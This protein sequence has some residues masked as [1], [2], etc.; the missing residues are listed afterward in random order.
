MSGVKACFRIRMQDG[1]WRYPPFQDRGEF[2][3]LLPR[4][5]AAA[6]EDVTP[7]SIDAM[8]EG[9]QPIEIAGDSMVLV[10]AGDNLPKPHTD[11][12]GAIML[13]ALKLSLDGFQLRNHSLPLARRYREVLLPVSSWRSCALVM[14]F[15]V[16][17]IRFPLHGRTAKCSCL[18]L[19]PRHRPSPTEEWV[20]FPDRKSTRLN[21]SDLGIS[22][23][24]FC[25]K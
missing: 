6:N 21:S 25:L 2:L 15:S 19:P 4:G 3:P 14:A 16:E 10:I 20:G 23:A 17:T 9:T 7:Q 12:T 11:L 1:G 24:V 8:S 18:F 5:L 22:Y 13:P